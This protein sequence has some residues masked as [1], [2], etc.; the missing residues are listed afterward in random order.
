MYGRRRRGGLGN[1]LL[2]GVVVGMNAASSQTTALTS[3]SH[4]EHPNPVR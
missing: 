4:P 2:W 3:G 1:G